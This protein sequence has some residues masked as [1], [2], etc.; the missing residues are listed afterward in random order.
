LCT[1]CKNKKAEGEFIKKRLTSAFIYGK[2]NLLG[3][4]KFSKNAAFPFEFLT[5]FA[6]RRRKN[7]NTEGKTLALGAISRRALGI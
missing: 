7:G 1:E 6:R 5:F 3:V 2:I 4:R